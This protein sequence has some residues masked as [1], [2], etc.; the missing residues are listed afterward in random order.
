MIPNGVGGRS[1]RTGPAAEG[2]YVLAVGTLE[3][4]KNLAAAQ[5]AARRLGVELRVVGAPGW[6]GVEVDG[7]A[8][9]RVSDEELAG[10]YRGARC[11]AYP[12]LYE[13]FGIPVLEAMACGT[14]VVTSA[15]RR[16]GG[17]RRRRR[18]AR[19]PARPGVDR[20]GDRGGGRAAR[21]A[22]RRAGSSAPA[23][24]AG[25]GRGRDAGGSTRRRPRDAARR[26][27][28]GRARPAAD[29]RRDLR[30]EPA[31]PAARARRRRAPLRGAHAPARTS[32]RPA[33]SRSS[34]RARLQELRMALAVPRRLRRLR[35]ALA[36]FQHAL[37]LALP[38]PG[39]RHRPRPLVRARPVVDGPAA[40]G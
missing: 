1:R 26:R 35:P 19:R 23:P 39:G 17:G 9:T 30:R 2:D 7:L 11:L 29:G 18:G 4:R 16:D 14:P 40:T 10:L 13:G 38:L 3:P 34:S 21:R 33:S 12:S 15:R 32:S 22:A 24:S 37:P 36:H 31:P 20:R 25:S 27:R 28:R 6:G 5:E 8:R